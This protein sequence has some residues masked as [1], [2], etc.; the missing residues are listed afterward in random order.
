MR[1][2]WYVIF[3]LVLTLVLLG[4]V[5]GCRCQPAIPPPTDTPEPELPVTEVVPTPTTPPEQPTTPPE[6]ATIPPEALVSERIVAQIQDDCQTQSDNG[7]M[8][9]DRIAQD[10]GYSPFQGLMY[11]EGEVIITGLPAETQKATQTLKLAL[12][13]LDDSVVDVDEQ[14]SPVQVYQIGDDESVE[15]VICEINKLGEKDEAGLDVF[16]EPNYYISPAPWTG[17]GSFWTQNGEWVGLLPGGGFTTALSITFKSQWAFS[18]THIG[19]F[20]NGGNRLV[21]DKGEGVRV[22]IFD[23]SPFTDVVGWEERVFTS[24][25]ETI[26][27]TVFH[28]PLTPAPNCPGYDRHITETVVSLE[29]QDISNHG[30]FVAGLVHAVAPSSTIYLVR[31]LEDDG[32]G[33][34]SGIND[35]IQSFIDKT[36]QEETTLTNTVIN[37]S[38]GVHQPMTPTTYGLPEE[39]VSLQH[40]LQ[41]AVDQGAIVVAAAGNDSFT[42]TLPLAMEIPANFPFVIGVAASDLGRGRGCFSNAGVFTDTGQVAAPGGDGVNGTSP[43]QIPACD[44]GNPDACLVSISLDSETGYVYWVG[45]SFAAP[46][47]SGEAALLLGMGNSP[48]QVTGAITGNSCPSTDTS[49]PR[50]I[51]NLPHTLYGDDYDC[52]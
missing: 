9:Q 23:T 5:S 16:A 28:P 38:L 17:G 51:I 4:L 50:G 43:C 12:T 6:R 18:T 34:L 33:S 31:V 30:L 3:I 48:S 20:D 46:L 52:P 35:G 29:D 45:T 2:R 10:I 27:L 22:A 7:K 21:E 26:P 24:S 40:V 41:A 25:G 8:E 14:K 11:V 49:I 44:A 13:A 32:C 42:S 39:V 19:L 47:V 1:N 36:L 37:L 15:Q